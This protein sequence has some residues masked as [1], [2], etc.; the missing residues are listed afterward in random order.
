MTHPASRCRRRARWNQPSARHL[1][2]EPLE[3]RTLLN[4]GPRIIASTPTG[5][6]A[7]PLS[8]VRVTFD[9]GIDASSFTASD[10]RLLDPQGNAVA[11]SSVTPVVGSTTQFNINFPVQGPAGTYNLAVGP[12]VRDTSGN[13]MDQ[14]ANN[15]AGESPGDVFT[16]S[17]TLSGPTPDQYGYSAFAVPFQNTDLQPGQP[18]VFTIFANGDTAAVAVNL[19]S[20]V[21][22]FYGV[23]YTGNN[24]LYVSTKGLIS[25][26]SPNTSASNTNLTSSPSQPTIAVLWSDWVKNSGTPMLLGKFVDV[27]GDGI[28]DQLV[29]EWNGVQRFP[30]SQPITFEAILQ[31]NTGGNTPSI[32][33]SYVNLNTGNTSSANGA[34]AAI[35]I[36]AAG[37][38][39][40]NRVLVSFRAVSSFVGSGQSLQF[41]APPFGNTVSGRL[42]LDLNQDGKP[43]AGEPG[44][45]G[46]TVYL[47]ANRDGA[48]EAGEP[49]TLT[50]VNGNY[51]FSGLTPGNYLVQESLPAGWIR[52]SPSGGFVPAAVGPDGFGY[53]ASAAPFQSINLQ[54]GQPGVFS[55]LGSGDDVSVP[56]NLSTNSFN[57]YGV[58]YTGASSLFVN[59]NGLITF[60][61]ANNAWTN[62]DLSTSPLQPAIATLWS[63]WVN[64]SATPMIL[65]RFV[66]VN[67]DGTP[68][69]LVLEWN[70]LQSHP[71][72]PSTVS[73]AAIL[74]LNTG[75]TPGDILLD[76]VDLD[77]GT[78]AVNNGANATVG[79]ESTA[80]QASNLLLVNRNNGSN[81]LIGTGKAVL[82]SANMGGA[83]D[84]AFGIR[85]T[86][87]GKDFANYGPPP[88]GNKDF[89]TL[90]ENGTLTLASSGVLVNDTSAL[91]N[92]TLTASLVSGP[93]HGSLT[94]HAD[95][96]FTYL[97]DAEFFGVDS[98]TYE[99]ND[100]QPSNLAVVTLTVSQVADPPLVTV[101]DAA[102]M[103]G[104]AIPLSLAALT[105][106]TD[107]SETLAVTLSG[108]PTGDTLSAG[109]NQG[110]G[111]WALTSDQLQ[112]LTLKAPDNGTFFLTL[113]ATSTA[114]S[115][116]ATAST[117]A[118]FQVA[119]ANA[120]PANLQLDLSQT[121]MN[122]GDT[123]DLAGVFADPGILDSHTVLI[124]W[125][126]G[127]QDTLNLAAGLTSFGATSHQYLA[128]GTHKLTVT[129]TDKDGAAASATADVLVVNV[130][131]GNVQL[132]LS[133]TTISENDTVALSG[134]FADPGT[135][136]THTVLITWGDGSQDSLGLAAGQTSFD[137]LSH[138]YLDDGNYTVGV[139]VT[140]NAGGTGGA[141][142][143]LTV[144]NVA[145]ASIQLGLSR[146]TISEN[147]TV[148]LSG[149]FA[150]PGSLDTH[151]VLITWGDGS[152]DSVSLPE[153]Q[154]SFGGLSHQYLDDGNYTV[155]VTVTDNAGGT[156]GATTGLTVLNVAPANVQLALSQ[157]TI[158]E[159]DSVTLSGSFA[160]PGTLDT[161]SVLITW[162][163]GGQDSVNLARGQTSFG[164]LTHHYLDDGNYSVGVTVTDNGGGTG[165]AT[166]SLAVLNVAPANIQLALSQT[167]ISEN[168]TVALSG[169]F[170]DPGTLDTHTVLIAWGDGSQDSLSLAVGQTTFGGLS[171]RYLDNGYYTVGITVTD[172]GGGTGSAT[173]GIS[174]LNVAPG[175]LQ[176][177]LSP[178]S[179]HSGDPVALSG[180]FADPG[181]LDTHTVSISWGDGTQG[182]ITLPAGVTSFGGLAHQYGPVSGTAH[183]Q[184][185]VTVV[186]KD[187]ASTSANASV[188]V[189]TD[190]AFRATIQGPSG[191]VRGQ[192]RVFLL[193]V[194]GAGPAAVI[195]YAIDWDG[196][197]RVDQIVTG[198]D[199]TTVEHVFTRTGN[200]TARVTAADAGGRQ[201]APASMRLV[202][203]AVE[204]QPDPLYPGKV[205]L[206]V[207]GT[208]GSDFILFTRCARNTGID[209]RLNGC[210]FGPFVPTSRIVAYG[211]AGDDYIAVAPNIT[212]SAWLFGGP[213]NDVLVGGGGNDVLVGDGGNDL[214]VGG[215]GRNLLIGG[216]GRDVVKGGSGDDILIGG[217]TAF[218]HHDLA[219]WSIMQEWTSGHDRRTRMANLRGDPGAGPS[220]LNGKTFLRQGPGS[221]STIDDGARDVL[222]GVA[223]R[224][225]FAR[226][227]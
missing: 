227:V 50:D 54:A 78:A 80:A 77:A 94:F 145:P 104:S 200:C 213:G 88:V 5:T 174:V 44:L 194:P 52:T 83:Y 181:S 137:G 92:A 198:P 177:S 188:Q 141:T 152:Q 162:G 4:A 158:S 58:S 117:S 66:D 108:V 45:S 76:Y 184:V 187:Q 53:G 3:D 25:L 24:Q 85:Q 161:H 136:D 110:N 155:G 197:G 37:S 46:W 170:A 140:D 159:N 134:S 55:I 171:H 17:I 226:L 11:I 102:G 31:L 207:G 130:A 196:D 107:G 63:D 185:S 118:T 167:T 125:G 201:G 224:D 143:S 82:I 109:I 202:I 32:T 103:E 191:G 105:D 139:T 127:S 96:S 190:Q 206:I 33:L 47:D 163:D 81:P 29:I 30:S 18:G 67:G 153:G 65:G 6:L 164:G 183:Y 129:V 106:D 62:T 138:Q 61:A 1:Y 126:D 90:L 116:G 148:A 217:R 13:P 144:L 97:P 186:D 128:T 87:S 69:Q 205:A 221:E 124:V 34:D 216:D 21:F 146:T 70:A 189:T 91:P 166:T 86:V 218:D 39:S 119:V 79:I 123:L 151:T 56:V 114:V 223:G 23:N 112:G 41:S 133:Q 178:G 15:L 180:T 193:G 40:A 14:N 176:L 8:N 73:F 101:A 93:S 9:S 20:N 42:Y 35:G 169:K 142:A 122:Q 19:G 215:S 68:D 204:L 165:A 115:N 120:A 59:S 36:K 192:Q 10:V 27:N 150:D 135:L 49:F 195:H 156:G 131:P 95:G 2:L 225:W 12:D 168:D 57:F 209:V 113:T 48:R 175:N 121:S 210:T 7:A 149:S 98:F 172:N 214:L 147:D 60:G 132:A 100:V 211:Q 43:E 219:L 173:A 26:G 64:S 222:V 89:Y 157:T 74:Q 71:S 199:H 179:V 208:T 154:T 99:A 16:T 72:S 75:N 220:R 22:S 111:V 51:S 203:H 28:S 160:D 38:Q 182:S 84:V 212:L